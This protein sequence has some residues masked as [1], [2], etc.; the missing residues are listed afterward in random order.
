M[1]KLYIFTLIFSVLA[2]NLLLSCQEKSKDGRTDTKDSGT[3]TFYAD[4]SFSP[5]LDEEITV[6]EAIYSKAKVNAKYSTEVEAIKM[7]LEQKTFL[8]VCA[9]DFTQNEKDYIKGNGWSYS[10]VPIGYDGLSFIINNENTDSCLTV[11]QIK[12]ILT[13]KLNDWHDV[14]PNTKSKKIIVCFD[15]EESSATRYASDSILGGK[16]INSKNIYAAKKSAD[17]LKFVEEHTNSIG[18]IGSNWLNDKRDTTNIT[19]KRNIRVVS[20]SKGD[21]ATPEN[22]YLPYQYYLL[23]GDYPFPRTVYALIVDPKR[24]LPWSFGN[25]LQSPKGQRVVLKSAL[26]PYRGDLTF[27]KVNVSD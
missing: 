27:R 5:I 4:E 23:T 2:I 16:Q 22:S 20:L 9:R 8:A 26:L 11:Q 24:A 10:S 15:N 25:F 19:F 12:D 6:F 21:K 1:K 18:I 14:N 3:M 17:V 7:L 13:G